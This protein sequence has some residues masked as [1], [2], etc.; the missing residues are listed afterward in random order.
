[1]IFIPEESPAQGRGPGADWPARS[2]GNK[3]GRGRFFSRGR[4]FGRRGDRAPAP[5]L[6]PTQD[7]KWHMRIIKKVNHHQ[8]LL[9]LIDKNASE[10]PQARRESSVGRTRISDL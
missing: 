6:R 9:C 1:M 2:A 3:I 8:L 4:F 5:T 7:D 10:N